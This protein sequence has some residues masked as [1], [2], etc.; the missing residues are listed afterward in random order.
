MC[1]IFEYYCKTCD[2]SIDLLQKADSKTKIHCDD[3]L[4]PMEKQTPAPY[5]RVTGSLNRVI[6]K[7]KTKY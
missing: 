3:C 5:G 7:G 1:P 2:K 6:Q 4:N